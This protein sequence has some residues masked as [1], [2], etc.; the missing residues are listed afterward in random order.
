[1]KL[2]SK[3]TSYTESILSKLCPILNLLCHKNMQIYELY[4]ETKDCYISYSDFIDA[5]DC[6]FALGKLEFLENEEVL[7]YVA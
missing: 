7:H 4:I 5:L 1:M 3:V 2:P 6:L